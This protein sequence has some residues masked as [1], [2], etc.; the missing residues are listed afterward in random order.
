MEQHAYGQSLRRCAP[1]WEVSATQPGH[2]LGNIRERRI[3]GESRLNMSS[4]EKAKPETTQPAADPEAECF[5]QS[6]ECKDCAAEEAV[7]L[8]ADLDELLCVLH[9]DPARRAEAF[10][11]EWLRRFNR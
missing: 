2:K 1:A 10:L 3:L 9:N 4:H 7:K 5:E 6:Q 8:P 11:P